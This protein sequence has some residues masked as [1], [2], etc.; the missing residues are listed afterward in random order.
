MH[1]M[2]LNFPLESHVVVDTRTEDPMSISLD[3]WNIVQADKSD[4]L[5][6]TGSAGE[7]RAKILGTAD[8]YTVVLV[9]AQPGYRGTPHTHTY[10]E[11]HYLIDGT[12]T[13]QGRDMKAGDGYA[14]A[15]GSTHDEFAT[16][17]GATYIT[18]FK[19]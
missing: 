15:A 19:L 13:N 18:I 10:A 1:I 7:A 14:A 2:P 4:W 8:G 5:P 17:T 3:G 12:V 16:D 9:E 11:F 6:W